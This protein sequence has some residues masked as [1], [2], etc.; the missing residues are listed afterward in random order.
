MF[1]ENARC[2]GGSADL[3]QHL[4]VTPVEESPK[5]LRAGVGWAK[6]GSRKDLA[7]S[8]K[9]LAR[10]RGGRE[11]MIAPI[12]TSTEANRLEQPSEGAWNRY[13]NVR[14]SQPGGGRRWTRAPFGKMVHTPFR[15]VTWKSGTESSGSN[16]EPTEAATCN[17]LSSGSGRSASS[18]DPTM[19]VRVEIDASVPGL[20]AGLRITCKLLSA[21]ATR[22]EF[23]TLEFK[24]LN[25]LD[26]RGRLSMADAIFAIGAGPNLLNLIRITSMGGSPAPG[27]QQD[28]ERVVNEASESLN[29]IRLV[30]ALRGFTSARY[31]LGKHSTGD[32][33]SSLTPSENAM[34]LATTL[35]YEERLLERISELI[36]RFTGVPVRSSLAENQLVAPTSVR[37]SPS[38]ITRVL[39][40]NEGFGTNQLIH[41]VA[42]IL[43]TPLNGTV[44]V[45]EPETH[46]HPGA[47][48]DVAA[49]VAEHAAETGKQF[50]DHHPLRTLPGW[51]TMAG[52]RAGH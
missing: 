45:E 28:V 46:L 26:S 21:E 42:Q 39:P 33:G 50:S 40:T 11:Q 15:S 4:G 20:Q 9:T 38:S 5:T 44:I 51:S 31:E 7:S 13:S 47:Q 29:D 6:R 41:L 17:E 37:S 3:G 30:P 25:G 52:T 48:A 36:R 1:V 24:P 16:R 43:L 22:D 34:T 12:E 19:A 8:Y 2:R 49:W 35:A 10:A 18:A 23:G 14:T 32:V 27:V